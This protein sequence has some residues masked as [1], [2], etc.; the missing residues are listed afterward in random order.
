MVP[1]PPVPARR[2]ALPTA[3]PPPLS[4][5]PPPHTPQPHPSRRSSVLDT[6]IV[7]EYGASLASL[8]I[9]YNQDSGLKGVDKFVV[10]GAT[11]GERGCG[12]GSAVGTL[13]P[14]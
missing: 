9:Y 13:Q 7:Q 8:S 4:T 5:P 12:R 3:P 11:S 1:L 14:A 2:C 6:N 10:G